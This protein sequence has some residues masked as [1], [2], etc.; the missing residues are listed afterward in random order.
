MRISTFFYILRQGIRNIFRNKWYSLASVA[1]IATCLFLFG[2]F[3]SILINFDNIVKKA[4]ED[5]SVVV[6]FDE[7]LDNE[8]IE[9]IG[10]MIDNRTEVSKKEFVSADEAWN[11]FSE[12][13]FK[14]SDMVFQENPL[15]DYANYRV[16]IRD[17]SMQSSLVT[18]LESIDGVRQVRR[19]ELIADTLAG[20]NSLVGYV[21]VGIIA[22]L[23]IVS[24]FLISNTVTIGISVRKEEIGIMKYIGATDFFVRSPF[25]IEGL[26]IGLLG[27]AVPLVIIYYVYNSVTA[28]VAS[29]FAILTSVLAFL[30]I[31][32]IFHVLVPLT[33]GIGIGIGF[34][35]S[36]TTVRR[37][38]H[39]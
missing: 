5:V 28:Y 26:I 38:L 36:Y 35:G 14:D 25:V 17:V 9:K 1:T 20:V 18:Y 30:N 10:E 37:H 27:A 12:D 21:S 32:E 13:Y 19:S 39:V 11:E 33:L 15:K 34:I 6:F 4:E 8:S 3:Y 23:F 29:K 7:G 31:N 16:Y 24:L 2:I 22:L